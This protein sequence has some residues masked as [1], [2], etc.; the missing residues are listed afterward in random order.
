MWITFW[1]CEQT[2][3]ILEKLPVP[4]VTVIGN[5]DTLGNGLKIFNDIF[6][7]T[8][9][10]FQC[11]GVFFI[12]A[13]NNNWESDIVSLDEGI[14]LLENRQKDRYKVIVTHIPVLNGS[15]FS[16]RLC[17]EYSEMCISH[18]INLSLHGHKHKHNYVDNFTEKT[19][20]V[21]ADAILNR[22]FY[23]FHVNSSGIEFEMVKF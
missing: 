4:Y 17:D 11:N 18:N 5:H 14:S 19:S 3:K 10:S 22:V 2:I 23:L 21:V 7:V 13:N 16:E 20:M 8:N 15:R 12:I 1:I 9:F 6:G